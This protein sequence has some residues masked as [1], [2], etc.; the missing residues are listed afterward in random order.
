MY[1]IFSEYSLCYSR[2][3][4]YQR[5]QKHYNIV[6]I[7]APSQPI[8]TTPYVQP[9]QTEEK[10]LLYVLVKRPDE[11]AD[12]IQSTVQPIKPSKPEV[13]FIRYNSKVLLRFI[14]L[15]S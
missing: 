6:F 13:H 5:P 3:I 9:Q 10:T 7:K 15:N 2:P 4:S 12:V 11:Q 1:L 8:A 14:V